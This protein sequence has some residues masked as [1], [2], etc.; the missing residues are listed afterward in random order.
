MIETILPRAATAAEEIRLN[1]GGPILFSVSVDSLETFAETGEIE[2]DL[3]LVTRFLGE[4]TLPL[5]RQALQKPIPLDVVQVDN[6]AY[7]SLGGD[8]LQNVGK[9]FKA[10]PNING[11]RGLR[12]ATIKAAAQAGPEG[13]TAIDVL[14]QFPT[15][16]IDLKLGD[17]QTLRRSLAVYFEYNAA[18]VAAVQSQSAAEAAQQ[19]AVPAAQNL[20]Q[21]GPYQY[22]QSAFTLSQSAV[23]QTKEGLQVNYDF[24]VKI[25]VPEGLTQPAPVILRESPQKRVP[26]RLEGWS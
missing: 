1:V 23:R 17:L 11:A 6:L 7:S 3:Q 4:D 21:A 18:A 5:L 26:S 22:S 8:L 24:D 19:S 25:Y 16:S 14:Q 12:G 15:H 2:P 20:S 9:I 13:W 10:H